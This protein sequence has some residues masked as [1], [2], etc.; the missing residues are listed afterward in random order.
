MVAGLMVKLG[1]AQRVQ[2]VPTGEPRP[3]FKYENGERTDQ[4]VRFDDGRPVFGFTAAVA[5][6]GER[7]DSVQVE[8]PL[9]TLPEVPFGTLL[10]GEGE[11]RLRVS[12]KDQYSVRAVVIVDGLK[13]AGSK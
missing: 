7:L 5:I 13:V 9:E 1:D 6:D 11:A 3:K 2:V 10:I 12:A 4:A 8:S